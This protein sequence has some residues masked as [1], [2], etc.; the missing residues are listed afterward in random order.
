VDKTD[1]TARLPRELACPDC[2]AEVRVTE[3][4]TLRARVIHAAT[5]LWYRR[6]LDHQVVGRIPCGTVVTHRGPYKRPRT[7]EVHAG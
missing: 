7:G 2:P 1:F 6:Y 4:T 5:C 3:G